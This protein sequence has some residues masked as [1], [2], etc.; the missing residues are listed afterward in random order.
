L[1]P[2]RLGSGAAQW[3]ITTSG[4]FTATADNTYDIGASGANRARTIYAG[5]SVVAPLVSATNFLAS[6][7]ST[8]QNFTFV[9]ATGTSATT[10]NF[11][12]TTASSTNLFAS[13][14]QIGGSVFNV[15][16]GGNV[17]IGTTNPGAKLQV[18][19]ISYL[20]S[21]SPTLSGSQGQL[22]INGDWDGTGDA[23]VQ[24]E[25]A[26]APN[27]RLRLGYD[28]TNNLGYIQA[29]EIGVGNKNLSLNPAG[30]NVGIGTTTPAGP[31]Y[32]AGASR[33]LNLDYTL[34][35][36][37]FVYASFRRS[38]E[39]KWWLRSD[40]TTNELR[41]EAKSGGASINAL[42]LLQSGNVG[43]GTSTPASKFAVSGGA[44]IGS[45]YN[46]AAPTNGL[47]VEGNLGI[48][49]TNP[50]VKASILSSAAA[51]TALRISDG[52]NYTIDFGYTGSGV[53]YLGGQVGSALAL[54][55][56]GTE[57]V[58]ITTA[59]NV[60]I[61]TTTP[62]DKFDVYGNARVSG[63]GANGGFYAD[64]GA[65]VDVFSLT[66][67]NTVATGDLSITAY[68]GIG[69][70]GGKTNS[71]PAASGFGL[72]LNTSNNVGI[73]TTSPFAKLSVAGDAYIGGNLTATGTL[74]VLGGLTSLS[75]LLVTG[76]STLQNFTF[77]NATGT[78][79][80]TTNFF[81]ATASSTN[82]FASLAQI[83]G[84]A[85]NVVSNGSVGIGTTNP[86]S[87]LNVYNASSAGALV[88]A[89]NITGNT[90]SDGFALTIDSGGFARLIQRENN[91]I[92]FLTNNTEAMRILSGG[93][94]GIGTTTPAEKLSLA[95]NAYI[96]GN[97]TATGTVT[98][99]SGKLTNQNALA[100]GTLPNGYLGY[101]GYHDSVF[102]S[103][104]LAYT[105]G[106]DPGLAANQ[107]YIRDAGSNNVA[108]MMLF[109]KGN[110]SESAT[111]FNIYSAP[112][113][114]GAGTTPASL[115]ARAISRRAA[116]RARL[117]ARRLLARRTS[118]AASP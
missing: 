58:R 51:Q 78:S 2:L 83:G 72:Y 86:Q 112:T 13:L 54:N 43:V 16:A 76:S 15:T 65:L 69:L 71:T 48:G 68:G 89:N 93:N 18:K 74:S 24:I 103:N 111:R 113:S 118:P 110:G 27:K 105:G 3:S 56:N 4:H 102:L 41:F 95:G 60:G 61:G 12:S 115:T 49:T 20:G 80:T 66:R 14:A 106:G 96:G 8:L 99:Q 36:G 46:I 94:V 63:L 101:T 116:V 11:F 59:G 88:L 7:S 90:G 37:G 53:G 47:I 117:T 45:N 22:Y 35:D 26:T 73:G 79:A 92:A 98:A 5:T 87:T 85:F 84:S 29:T 17:G 44:S 77:V 10:T 40:T 97:L 9:N 64:N 108:G 109:V 39:E 55:T 57:K 28:T 114:T 91:G 81:A 70:T 31:L 107:V 6:G 34:S 21:A 67:Q 62:I 75:N 32:V 30:G 1:R 33:V 82:L 19:G 38:A 50:N 25:G 104:N 42:T 23:Q 100:L 52:V